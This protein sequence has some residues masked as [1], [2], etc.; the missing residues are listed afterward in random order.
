MAVVDDLAGEAA[1]VGRSSSDVGVA[2]AGQG[3]AGTTVVARSSWMG[4]EDTNTCL[5][6]FVAA[7]NTSGHA[8]HGPGTMLQMQ[9]NLIAECD[10]PNTTAV[11]FVPPPSVRVLLL[12][13][14]VS[15]KLVGEESRSIE[16]YLRKSTVPAPGRRRG[17]RRRRPRAEDVRWDLGQVEGTANGAAEVTRGSRSVG[18]GRP[19]DVDFGAASPDAIGDGVCS[20]GG[21]RVIG[22]EQGLAGAESDDAGK[23][24][25]SMSVCAFAFDMRTRDDRCTSA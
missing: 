3:A 12:I 10:T 11:A 7:G 4:V 9:V 1:P 13:L 18:M 14:S 15:G 17:F 25:E 24:R 21:G 20:W 8:D 22:G 2:V 16:S 23:R 5:A 6:A 19:R